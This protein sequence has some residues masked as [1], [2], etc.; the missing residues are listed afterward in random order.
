MMSQTAFSTTPITLIH[1]LPKLTGK[2]THAWLIQAKKVLQQNAMAIPYPNATHGCL[3]LVVN[4]ETYKALTKATTDFKAPAWP[5][6]TLAP[7]STTVQVQKYEFKHNQAMQSKIYYDNADRALVKMIHDGVPE[8][9]LL[10]LKSDGVGYHGKTA[11]NFIEHLEKTHGKVTPE[12]IQKIEKAMLKKWDPQIDIEFLWD[13][14]NTGRTALKGTQGE[15]TEKN[16]IVKASNLIQSLG[17][18]DLNKALNKFNDLT[19]AEQTLTKFKTE[20]TKAHCDLSEEDKQTTASTGYHA[21]AATDENSQ[22]NTPP[23]GTTVENPDNWCW[24]HGLWNHSSKNCQNPHPNHV[25]DSSIA[26]MCG[27]CDRI[28]R[29]RGE[30]AVWQPRRPLNRRNDAAN[31]RGNNNDAANEA[32]AQDED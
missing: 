1:P 6:A 21:N 26:N 30:R 27:G 20:L 4:E 8:Q 31:N 11:L 5:T 3:R 2:P 16:L 15:L 32:T 24:T 19:A 12:Q 14:L 25:R 29:R 28:R 13:Q 18:K 7:N 9:Y 17:I 10:E 22:E 23:S